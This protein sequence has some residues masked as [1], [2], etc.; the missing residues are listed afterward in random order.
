M[1]WWDI[2]RVHAVEV[3]AFP[4]TA[5]SVETFWSELARVPETR[6]YVVAHSGDRV[7]GYAGL[8]AIGPD[9]DVQTIAVAPAFR[10]CGL[11]SR[12]LDDLLLEAARR[13]C[14]RV[15]LEV[16]ASNE[17]AQR[18]YRRRGFSVLSRRSGYYGPGADALIM[19]LRL[20]HDG[21]AA[22]VLR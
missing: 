4:G 5:W 11:G 20:S 1:R 7:A 8:M 6:A 12:L 22:E 14:S 9:A 18:L 21:E 2:A 10:R 13:G 3:G 19:R 16:A 17:D 15:T